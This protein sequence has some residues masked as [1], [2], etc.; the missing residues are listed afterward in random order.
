MTKNNYGHKGTLTR[1]FTSTISVALVLLI[2]GL[3]GVVSTGTRSLTDHIRSEIGFTMV[4][5]DDLT[6]D[7]TDAI[8]AA[9]TSAPYSLNVNF[10][11]SADIAAEWQ[12]DNGEDII[13]VLGV[14]P[15]G[16]TLDVKVR[17]QYASTDSLAPIVESLASLDGVDA[18]ELNGDL[19]D[20]ISTNLN[21]VS[22]ILGAVALALLLVSF[23]LINNTVWLTV[24]SRRFLIHTMKLVGATGAFIRRPFIRTGLYSGAIAGII[25]SMMLIAIVY[26][27]H[28]VYPITDQFTSWSSLAWIFPCM[29]I[30]GMIICAS[31]SAFATNRYLSL[32]YDRLV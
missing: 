11:S 26:A 4:L 20:S 3:I 5:N 32:D 9:V 7:Q 27:L 13:E 17:Q 29:V 25:A 22:L 28:S 8:R 18:V 10:R 1:Q 14:N 15:F 30:V 24:Y 6:E 16:A 2:L 31:A 23:V 21:L 12:R 19:V